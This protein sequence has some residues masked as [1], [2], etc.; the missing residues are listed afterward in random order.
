VFTESTVA[1][2][3]RMDGRK[4]RIGI[5]TQIILDSSSTQNFPLPTAKREYFSS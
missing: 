1:A 2:T 4:T 3:E 5:I